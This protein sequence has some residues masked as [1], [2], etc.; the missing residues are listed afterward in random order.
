MRAAERPFLKAALNSVSVYNL[1]PKVVGSLLTQTDTDHMLQSM[2]RVTLAG[3]GSPIGGGLPNVAGR[4]HMFEDGIRFVPHFPFERGLPYLATFDSRPLGHSLLTD[5]VTLEFSLPVEQTAFPTEVTHV[6]PS[7]D[8]LP[9]NVLRFYVCFS[10]PMQR[11]RAAAEISLLGPNGEPATD[12]L[13][14]APVELWDRATR[15]LTILL[16]PGRLKRGVGPN[17]ELGP[18][19]ITGQVYT[20]AVGA[21]MTDMFGRRLPETVYKRFLATSALRQPVE[22]GQ[23]RIVPPT[24]NSRRPLS[25]TFPRPL[26]WA[27]LSDSITIASAHGQPINGRITVE[28][29]EQRWTLTPAS[30]WHAGDYDVWVSSHLEDVCGNNLIAP[31][32]RVFRSGSEL[33]P[34]VATRSIPFHLG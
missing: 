29:C 21:R 22:I 10:N 30:P 23:W 32:D 6:F 26:D 7:G 2:F 1:H 16:D 17:R 13:Y 5:A 14:R 15:C 19:L 33:Q 28:Q 20:L 8:R 25:V 27:L 24:I 18:P 9:E 31:F 3:S 4:H 34:D 11:G 12:A